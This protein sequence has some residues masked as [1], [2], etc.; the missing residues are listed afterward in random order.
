MTDRLPKS[1]IFNHSRLGQVHVA[2]RE[3]SSRVSGRWK[4]G[5]A[6]FN[7]PHF[8]SLSEILNAI[9]SLSGRM[10][11]RKI[12][13]EYHD[14]QLI[15]LDGLAFHISRQRI[16]P[17]AVI[18]T[19]KSGN[20]YIEVG[21]GLRFDDEETTESVS[22]MMRRVASKAASDILLPRAEA[23]ADSLGLTVR[24]WGIMSG[25]HVLGRCSSDRRIQLS[26]MN[27][28]LTS[29]LRDY[30]VFHE[31]AHLT[32]MNHSRRFHQLCNAYCGGREA[33]L[34]RDLNAYEW[35]VLRR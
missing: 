15:Q 32:E 33:R 3:S 8:L 20:A 34:I 2:R 10:L 24:S 14:G 6:H 7:V 31:L 13:L 4:D 18:A 35:P 1:F 27:L 19:L 22:R 23:L 25:H 17:D 29:E 5:R 11:A 16:K 26:Y 21:S 28:F 12:V 9:E 30:I